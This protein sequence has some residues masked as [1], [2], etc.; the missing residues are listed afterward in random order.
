MDNKIYCWH[1]S[2]NSTFNYETFGGG[3]G[4]AGFIENVYRKTKNIR[5][6]NWIYII[7]S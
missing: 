1:A 5:G 2:Y 6:I 3:F 4:N 7:H